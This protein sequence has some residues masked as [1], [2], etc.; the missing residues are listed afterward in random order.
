MI[1]FT[2]LFIDITYLLKFVRFNSLFIDLNYLLFYITIWKQN[3]NLGSSKG[4]ERIMHDYQTIC[5]VTIEWECVLMSMEEEIE[6]TDRR[7]YNS[8]CTI[9]LTY[10]D[11]L[12]NDTH[13]LIQNYLNSTLQ[14]NAPQH[15]NIQQQ[16]I[17]QQ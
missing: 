9:P 13:N 11:S 1:Y 12:L 4:M 10:N 8:T 2:Y 17:Q 15:Q 5:L 14:Q 16:Y 3:V 7:T 6:V